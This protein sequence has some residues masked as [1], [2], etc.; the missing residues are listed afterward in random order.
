VQLQQVGSRNFTLTTTTITKHIHFTGAFEPYTHTHKETISIVFT[1]PHIQASTPHLATSSHICKHSPPLTLMPWPPTAIW[2]KPQF[3]HRL[4]FLTLGCDGYLFWALR[5]ERSTMGGRWADEWYWH[6][7]EGLM[8]FTQL[9]SYS[10]YMHS[11]VYSIQ[12]MHKFCP[13]CPLLW[14]S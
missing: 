2:V 8:L 3:R 1:R 7:R 4:D 14:T 10:T 6:G 13:S 5:S 12:C 9:E 11:H